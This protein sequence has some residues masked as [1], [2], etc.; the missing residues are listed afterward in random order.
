M[1]CIIG[2][3]PSLPRPPSFPSMLIGCSIILPIAKG[4]SLSAHGL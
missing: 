3:P 4:K 1:Q 2:L